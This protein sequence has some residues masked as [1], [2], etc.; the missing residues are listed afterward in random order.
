MNPPCPTCEGS[1]LLITTDARGNRFARECECRLAL[2]IERALT[3]ARIPFRIEGDSDVDGFIDSLMALYLEGRFPFDKL[4]R[5]F[6]MTD[7]NKA[8]ESQ[9]RGEC[10]KVVLIP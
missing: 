3:Q 7:I 1:G 10:V 9:H 5:T 4:V 6:P 8:I 2:R